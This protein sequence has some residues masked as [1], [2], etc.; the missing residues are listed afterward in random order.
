MTTYVVATTEKPTIVCPEWCADD[1]EWHL[2][3][4]ANWEGRVVHRSGAFQL[5][6][7]FTATISST[8]TVDGYVEEPAYIHIHKDS[9]E[10]TPT[11]AVAAGKALLT[12]AEEALR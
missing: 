12:V 11:D 1:Q 5:G 7:G 10:L 6:A 2:S 3:E 9:N 4:L 8:T